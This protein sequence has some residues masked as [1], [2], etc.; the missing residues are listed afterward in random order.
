MAHTGTTQGLFVLRDPMNR[1]MPSRS[2]WNQHTYHIT[3]INEDGSIPATEIPNWTRYNNYRQNVQ[4]TIVTSEPQADATSRGAPAPDQGDCTKEWKLYAQICNRG[5]AAIMTMLPG[6][7]YAKD[8]RLDPEVICTAYTKAPIQPGGCET[9]TCTWT[10][11]PPL[12][13]DLWFRAN[14]D[15]KGG[16]PQTQCKN[17]NDLAFIPGTTCHQDQG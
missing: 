16:K 8:P 5:S 14:D 15:G 1:W 12:A 6:T 9:V 4:G 7:F 2:L 3:N 13:V 10:N 11:P 17:L